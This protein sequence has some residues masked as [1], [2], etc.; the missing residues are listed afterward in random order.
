[1]KKSSQFSK[2]HPVFNKIIN[3][4]TMLKKLRPYEEKFS[5]EIANLLEKSKSNCFNFL[6]SK[7]IY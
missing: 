6:K 4:K 3:A 1:M 7:Y 5:S 2:N